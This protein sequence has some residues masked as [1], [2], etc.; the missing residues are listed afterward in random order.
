METKYSTKR[1]ESYLEYTRKTH[2]R[3]L[4]LSTFETI[5]ILAAT[6]W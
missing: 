5:S 6:I 3:L 2:G 1:A 4:L